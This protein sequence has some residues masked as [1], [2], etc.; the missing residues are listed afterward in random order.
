MKRKIF[1]FLFVFISEK[2]I[3]KASQKSNT[4]DQYLKIVINYLFEVLKICC[5]VFLEGTSNK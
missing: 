1:F 3:T 2:I 5:R 4:T